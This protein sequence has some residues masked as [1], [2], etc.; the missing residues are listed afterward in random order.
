MPPAA[1]LKS[2]ALWLLAAAILLAAVLSPNLFAASFGR[3][4]AD[5]WVSTMA[6]IAGLLGGVFG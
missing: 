6:A 5:V 1:R 2:R 4:L 3:M